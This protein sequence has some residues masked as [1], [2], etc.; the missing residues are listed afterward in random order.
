MIATSLL[1]IYTSLISWHL[2]EVIWDVLNGTGLAYIPFIV[3]LISGLRNAYEESTEKAIAKVEM[4]LAG[5]IIVLILIVIP[6]TDYEVDMAEVKYAITST[7]CNIADQS[8][9][10]DDTGKSADSAFSSW[11]GTDAHMPVMWALTNYVSASVTYTTIKAMGCSFNH[12]KLQTQL[13]RTTFNDESNE[14]LLD[15]F[16]GACYKP[17]LAEFEREGYGTLD[18]TALMPW[19]DPSYI[20][21]SMFLNNATKYYQ[22]DTAVMQDTGQVGFSYD[23]SNVYDQGHTNTSLSVRS[24]KEMWSSTSPSGIRAQLLEDLTTG[25]DN[26]KVWQDFSTEGFK[27]I[28]PSMTATQKQ[29]A[30]LAKVLTNR[31]LASVMSQA[32]LGLKTETVEDLNA[33][34]GTWYENIA[35]DVADLVIGGAAAWDGLGTMAQMSVISDSMKTAVPILISIAQMLIIII[36]PLAMVW[37]NYKLDNFVLLALGYFGLEFLNAIMQLG[38]YFENKLAEMAAAGLWEGELMVTVTVFLVGF[39]QL[40]L[41]PSLWMALIVATGSTAL[42]GMSG[43]GASN[44]GTYGTSGSNGVTSG[45]GNAAGNMSRDGIKTAGSAFGKK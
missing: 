42:K 30:Y 35:S 26:A 7:D 20:G 6:Y 1:D 12:Q 36:A 34:S 41:L 3:A 17:A 43:V 33:N 14:V 32:T 16:V 18:P 11:S 28:D 15:W 44:R 38:Y 13:S 2:Y 27:V 40:F 31:G 9:D 24:C 4:N 5:M 25:D 45:I 23:S 39:I 29:D 21:A 22:D 8:G 19:E 10:G 37:G